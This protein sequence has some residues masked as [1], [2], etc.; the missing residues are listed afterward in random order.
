LCL[1]ARFAIAHN[2]AHLL[3]TRMWQYKRSQTKPALGR[4]MKT[5]LLSI[6]TAAVFFAGPAQ[7]D[8]TLTNDTMVTTWSDSF[9]RGIYGQRQNFFLGDF[10]L[11]YYPRY[12]ISYRDHSRSGASNQEMDTS[13][14]PMFGIPDA[15]ASRGKT[16]SLNFF[17]VSDNAEYDVPPATS[18]NSIYGYFKDMLQYPTNAYNR[19]GLLTN[20]WSQPNP[21]NLYQ[22][23]VIGD[24]AYNTTDGHPGARD[25]SYG[26]RT[27]AIED[28]APFVDSWSNL[29]NVV[30]NAYINGP[31][32]W[33]NAPAYDHPANELQLIW[34]LTTL[35]SLG[36]DTNTYTA[37]MDFNTATVSSTNHC[38]VTGLS[39]LGNSLTFTFHADRMAPGFYVPDNVITNDC[40]GAFTLMPSLGNQFCEIFRITNLPAGNYQLNMDGSNVVAVTSAQLSAGYNN[41]TNYSGP[42]WA[43]KEEILGLMCD[44][45]DVSRSDASLDAHPGTNIL[46][47]N[48]ESWARARWP[49]NNNTSVDYY[50]A[51]MSDRESELQVEDVLIH[52]AVQQTN[53]TITI[54]PLP[55]PPTLSIISIGSQMV[56]T[57]PNPGYL[58]QSAPNIDGPFTTVPGA[59]SPYLGTIA[60]PREFFRLMTN[61]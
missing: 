38:T 4:T 61:Q 46:L 11:N 5:L 60:A 36:V 44:M 59:M 41:F 3:V 58:L 54:S 35:R 7:A 27:A 34:T 19:F 13:R 30:T 37:V 1:A 50:I 9:A 29:V 6:V 17:Y 40:R 21:Q 23:V 16:N 24:I 22:S 20:D 2:G 25:Y 51:Q 43:Q 56:L 14:V 32:L 42:F 52:A 31:N 45:L 18:S 57:W 8:L 26:G 28:G 33:F 47:E 12:F 39:R 53:H 48:Y 55:P 15:G 10:F 49:T